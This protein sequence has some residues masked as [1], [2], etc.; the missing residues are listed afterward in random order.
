MSVCVNT[1]RPEG[2]GGMLPRK[3]CFVY[4]LRLFLV[5]SQVLIRLCSEQIKVLFLDALVAKLFPDK[6]N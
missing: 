6:A 5:H 2:S 4:S 1:H 3:F